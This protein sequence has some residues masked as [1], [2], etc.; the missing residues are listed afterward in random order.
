L[1]SENVIGFE[2]IPTNFKV[3]QAEN[4]RD[5]LWLLGINDFAQ[6]IQKMDILLFEVRDDVRWRMKNKQVKLFAPQDMWTD[7]LLGVFIH[8]LSHYIDLY[9][10]LGSW[11][12]DVS[13][14]FYDISWQ[15][16][17]VLK[18]GLQWWDFVSG[19]SMTNKYEDFA[20]SLTYYVFHNGDFAK[21]WRKSSL[22][23]QKYDFIRLKVFSGW[24]FQWTDFSVNNIV[25]DYYRDITIINFSKENFWQYLKKS[26]K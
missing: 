11:K 2:Y 1:K 23:Q 15:S 3:S 12:T 25:R 9:Y 17:K 13:E 22:L 18:S 14:W 10:L 19:Y 24:A 5:F 16:T 8:E 20:E 26:I 21:K 7:E 6:L 4:T